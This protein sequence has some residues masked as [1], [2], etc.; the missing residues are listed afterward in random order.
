MWMP[1]PGK[2][3]E[4]PVVK[5]KS[6]WWI[7]VIAAVMALVF[8][9]GCFMLFDV[10]IAALIIGLTIAVAAA[11]YFFMLWTET[12]PKGLNAMEAAWLDLYSSCRRFKLPVPQPFLLKS[13]DNPFS[14]MP[15]TQIGM[16][17]G[18]TRIP[19]DWDLIIKVISKEKRLSDGTVRK[20]KKKFKLWKANK[21]D[22]VRCFHVK[23]E[24]K[25]LSKEILVMVLDRQVCDESRDATGEIS[26]FV[27]I[28]TT[29]HL[30]RMG[31]FYAVFDNEKSFM[32][33]ITAVESMCIY[34][35]L[36]ASLNRYRSV[37]EESVKAKEGLIEHNEFTKQ[38]I[39]A[40][41]AE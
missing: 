3:K 6:K 13:G 5:Q 41:G 10:T 14:A 19:I 9:L 30:L 7:S 27:P 23:T 20:L 37:T 29:G 35:S 24:A 34:E 2:T 25:D 31:L 40:Q 22:W 17:H 16:A 32:T 8:V 1:T 21:I 26:P 38:R 36:I 11:V 18:M 15:P 28:L 39:Q 4:R 33:Y 12:K